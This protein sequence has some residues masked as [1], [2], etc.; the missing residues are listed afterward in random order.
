MSDVS[1]GAEPGEQA[2]TRNEVEHA[3]GW[4]GHKRSIKANVPHTRI[5]AAWATVTVA[6]VLGIALID[7]I[8]ENTRSVRIDFFSSS[9]HIPVAVALLVAAVAGAFVVLAIGVARTTQLRLAV[10][11]RKQYGAADSSPPT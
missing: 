7:F 6:V 3:R 2:N 10:R 5:G 1:D 8:A 11:H 9:G 4:F